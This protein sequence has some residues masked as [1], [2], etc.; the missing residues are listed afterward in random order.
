MKDLVTYLVTHLV[1]NSEAVQVNEVVGE[2]TRLYEVRVAPTDLGKLIGKQGRTIRS[3]R[4]VVNAAAAHG[5]TRVAV[6]VM[7]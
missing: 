1:E 3:V 2:S 5:G 6:E 7:E 4:A